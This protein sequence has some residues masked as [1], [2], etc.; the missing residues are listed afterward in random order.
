MYSQAMQ[1]G[2]FQIGVVHTR[3]NP[4]SEPNESPLK[5]GLF[6][7]T[8]NADFNTRVNNR[9]AFEQLEV[10]DREGRFADATQP[11][12]WPDCG[13]NAVL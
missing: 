5:P 1:N 7:V 13:V 2:D 8:K 3:F 9:K 4:N 10:L 12:A 11:V 6:T